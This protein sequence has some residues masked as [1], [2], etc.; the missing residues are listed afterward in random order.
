MEKVKKFINKR[1]KLSL[2]VFLVSILIGILMILEFTNYFEYMSLYYNTEELEEGILKGMSIL[3]MI[4]NEIFL[5]FN[6][7]VSGILVFISLYNIAGYLHNNAEFM[8]IS[9]GLCIILFSMGLYVFELGGIVFIGSL[10]ILNLLG[11]IDQVKLMTKK[12][13]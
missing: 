13:K 4:S 3:P 7:L 1:S 5:T 12:D 10:V 2:L 6:I 9:T 11:Y 8:F